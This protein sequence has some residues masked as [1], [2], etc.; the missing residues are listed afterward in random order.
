MTVSNKD[1]TLDKGNP[2]WKDGISWENLMKVK[3]AIGMDEWWGLEAYP[4]EKLM[5]NVAN[6]RNIF[7]QKEKPKWAWGPECKENQ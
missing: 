5:V 1:Y 2:I 6:M 7:L 4:P 3:K